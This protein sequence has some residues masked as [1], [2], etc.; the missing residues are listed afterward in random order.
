M[1]NI[2]P[3]QR[4]NNLNIRKERTPFSSLQGEINRVFDDFF[5]NGFPD[6]PNFPSALAKEHML[7]PAVDIIEDDKGFKIEAELPGLTQDD[8][9]VTI[10][11]SYLTIKGHK[12]DTKETKSEN[13]VHRERYSGAY[14]RTIALPET[15]NADKANASFDKGLLRIEIPKKTEAVKQAKKLEIK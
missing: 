6:M 15:V 2:L 14:Q 12:E 4:S 11:D 10:T 5:N 7:A 13:F 3:W 1:V 9:D 8:V